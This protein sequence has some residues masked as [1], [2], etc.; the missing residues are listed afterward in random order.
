MPNI[1]STSV[2]LDACEQSPLPWLAPAPFPFVIDR[3]GSNRNEFS[4]LGVTTDVEAVSI[5]LA[6]TGD[7]SKNTAQSYRREVERFLFWCTSVKGK[8][9]SELFRED[10]L[11]FSKFLECIP[12]NWIMADR[13]PRSSNLWRPYLGQPSAATQSRTLGIINSLITYLVKAGWLKLNPFPKI[14]RHKPQSS[15]Q[16]MRSLSPRDIESILEALEAMPSETS[17]DR[18]LKA[19][20]TW[21]F[22]LYWTTGARASEASLPM[23]NFIKLDIEGRDVWV[24]EIVGKG[25]K[26]AQIPIA[27]KTILRLMEFRRC[28]KISALPMANDP[29]PI[30]PSLQRITP[31][32]TLRSIPKP[33]DRRAISK[34]IKILF[35]SAMSIS[36]KKGF[37]SSNLSKASTHWLRHTSI[38][39]FYDSTLDL[40][41]TQ[42]FARHENIN[43]TAGYATQDL[44][45]I[46]AAIESLG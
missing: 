25:N 9:I 41:L 20:D 42:Q 30:I 37:S 22:Y 11:E 29:I 6:D 34:R 45:K 18:T 27:E 33:L 14:N 4:S 38:R 1:L 3:A 15:K 40:K 19:R 39:E 21:L 10:F 36:E 7:R 46:R 13:K 8:S 12:P 32:G 16:T 5:W 28:L 23:S 17:K 2:C 44:S 24:W 43:T 35:S 26:A 31:N